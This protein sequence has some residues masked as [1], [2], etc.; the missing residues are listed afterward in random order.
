MKSKVQRIVRKVFHGLVDGAQKFR[1]PHGRGYYAIDADGGEPFIVFEN[2]RELANLLPLN[3]RE[4]LS[5]T[6]L[7]ASLLKDVRQSTDE[8]RSSVI[9]QEQHTQPSNDE[10][11]SSAVSQEKPCF[12]AEDPEIVIVTDRTSTSCWALLLDDRMRRAQEDILRSIETRKIRQSAL[13][14][15]QGR[16]LKL[17][18]SIKDAAN[19]EIHDTEEDLNEA[20]LKAER[21]ETRLKKLQDD[22]ALLK[23]R[24]SALEDGIVV[25]KTRVQRIVER[26]M[27]E[28]DLLTDPE[29]P[30][31]DTLSEESDD[32]KDSNDEKD[33]IDNQ[34][35][36]DEN[37]QTIPS[38]E[39]QA[40]VDAKRLLCEAELARQKAQFEFDCKEQQYE[41]D[42]QEYQTQVAT[43]ELGMTR[44]DFDRHNLLLFRGKTRA[45]IDAEEAFNYAKDHAQELGC[46]DDG[47]G[48][49]S[50]YGDSQCTE[51]S[52][53]S[54][55]E[56]EDG[57]RPYMGTATLAKVESW[58]ETLDASND[59]KI[60]STV[61]VDDWEAEPIGLSDTF[62]VLDEENFPREIAF[63]KKIVEQNREALRHQIAKAEDL[64]TV[65]RPVVRRRKS[66]RL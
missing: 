20:K 57:W 6:P 1:H 7:E 18:I 39:E 47:W 28:A 24:I 41:C 15:V 61:D 22:E 29:I 34:G 58:I 27:K 54:A 23:K 50:Y 25:N 42:L 44:S 37:S 3:P 59:P 10:D 11:P 4:M 36:T 49:E 13:R 35:P 62:S 48:Q 31:M 46:F 65:D 26:A 9:S 38:E 51:P 19:I 53:T 32:E 21:K 33:N 30:E 55:D 5:L 16:I 8:D 64:W 60:M 2:A 40:T 14:K 43:G 12:T 45:L 17:E 56:P 63:W 66:W 52:I